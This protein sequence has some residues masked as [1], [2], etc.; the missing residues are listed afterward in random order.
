MRKEAGSDATDLSSP[1]SSAEEG[2]QAVTS[3]GCTVC[4]RMFKS[5]PGMHKN[6]RSAHPEVYFREQKAKID[7]ST[8]H[9]WSDL[10]TE[11]MARHEAQLAIDGVRFMNMEL[12]RLIPNRTTESIKGKRKSELFKNLILKIKSEILAAGAKKSP[13]QPVSSLGDSR[14]ADSNSIQVPLFLVDLE[15]DSAHSVDDLANSLP[16]LTS[17]VNNPLDDTLIYGTLPYYIDDLNTNQT[18]RPLP[19]AVEREFLD[20][21]LLISNRDPETAKSLCL[22]FLFNVLNIDC[23]CSSVRSR[24]VASKKPAR[25]DK[26]PLSKRNARRENYAILQKL[27]RKNENAVMDR[28]YNNSSFSD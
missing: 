3:V 7:A 22:K 28:I 25:G 23:S 8:H 27:Y 11:N 24:C 21:A 4:T 13:A 14:P 1:R 26:T 19:S 2:V 10:E 5:F 20:E 18:L 12:K 6:L 17:D 15:S 9:V 16:L